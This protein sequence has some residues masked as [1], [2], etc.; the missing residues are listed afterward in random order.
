MISPF[1]FP[2]EYETWDQARERALR[3][4]VAR[5]VAEDGQHSVA[6]GDSR[7]D[8]LPENV[9][10]TYSCGTCLREVQRRGDF[11]GPWVHRAIGIDP[12][13][14]DDEGTWTDDGG[15]IV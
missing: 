2:R 3:E 12:P 7:Y 8:D 5:V 11:E 6:E 13:D 14:P 9:I 10:V 4:D 1:G 15:A